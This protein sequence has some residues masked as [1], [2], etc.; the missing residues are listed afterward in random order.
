[1]RRTGELLWPPGR[2]SNIPLHLVHILECFHGEQ[3]M[4]AASQVRRRDQLETTNDTV[5]GD[6]AHFAI[7]PGT[8]VAAECGF[9]VAIWGRKGGEGFRE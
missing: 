2:I 1:M 8:L 6:S 4:V 9:L 7:T 5:G 3:V